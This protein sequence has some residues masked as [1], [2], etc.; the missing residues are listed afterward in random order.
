[1]TVCP[2][3]NTFTSLYPDLLR[4]SNVTLSGEMTENLHMAMFDA[5]YTRKYQ[6]F[7]EYNQENFSNW[8]T[9]ISLVGGKTFESQ[10][11]KKGVQT[12]LPCTEG[13]YKQYNIATEAS[14]GTFSTPY[15]RQIFDQTIFVPMFE[16]KVFIYILPNLPKGSKIIIDIEYDIEEISHEEFIAVDKEEYFR[17]ADVNV[18]YRSTHA[19]LAGTKYLDVSRQNSRK[20]FSASG[21]CSISV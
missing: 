10:E 7:T 5:E 9:G 14:S 2:P 8:Y 3:R 6:E 15:F 11:V 19:N 13:A 17:M 21:P 18:G 1:M 12:G 20:E 4:T 16:S